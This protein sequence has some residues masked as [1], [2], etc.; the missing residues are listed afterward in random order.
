MFEYVK[1]ST[2]D[3][4]NFACNNSR[5]RKIEMIFSFAGSR[6][7]TISYIFL[8]KDILIA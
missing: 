7:V 8:K 5:I 4:T 1:D 2:N 6:I 3:K